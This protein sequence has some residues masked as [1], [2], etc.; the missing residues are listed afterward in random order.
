M[1]GLETRSAQS[2]IRA[3]VQS[4]WCM[5]I[6]IGESWG[7]MVFK[8]KQKSKMELILS[9]ETSES[10]REQVTLDQNGIQKE[11]KAGKSRA[12]QFKEQSPISGFG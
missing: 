7:Q 12:L 11:E 4:A 1:L 10:F 5:V 6:A 2:Q 3:A 9:G 8:R